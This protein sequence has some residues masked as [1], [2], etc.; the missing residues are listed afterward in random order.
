MVSK[1]HTKIKEAIAQETRQ[2]DEN[3]S[4]D[5]AGREGSGTKWSSG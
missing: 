2:G 5:P 4:W 3:L 1:R